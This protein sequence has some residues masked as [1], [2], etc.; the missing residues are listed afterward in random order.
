MQFLKNF[1]TSCLG[2]IIGSLVLYGIVALIISS[3]AGG[4]T[5]TVKPNTVLK[6]TFKSDM[7]EL[8]NNVE[9]GAADISSLMD[10]SV[11]MNDFTALIETAKAD[12]NIKGI[13][14]ELTD[15]T[16]MSMERSKKVHQLLT[17]FRA[18]GKFVLAYSTMYQQRDYYL[19]TAAE[20][21]YL[22]PLG[23][24]DFRGFSSQL[25][26]FKGLMDKLGVAPQIF[27]AGKFKSATEPFRRTDMSPENRLQVRE[28]MQG[29]YD[30]YLKAISEARQIPVAELQRIA[31]EALIRRPEDA[32][33]FKM[34]DELWYKDEVLAELRKRM[35]LGA[36]ETVEAVD[37][38]TYFK[39]KKDQIH[40]PKTGNKIAVVYAEGGIVDGEGQNGSIGGDKYARIIRE[41]REKD[42]V[43]A[44][45]L[46]INSGGGSALASDIIWRELELA[47]AKGIHIV[48]SMGGVAASGGYYIAANA[49]KIYAEDNT[50]TG[51]IGVFGMITNLR[52]LYEGKLG[53][54]MDT[55]RTGKYSTMSSDGGMYYTFS[56]EEGAM[57]QQMVDDIYLTFKKR[58]ADGRKMDIVLV[59]SFAQGRVWLGNAAQ[60]IGLVDSL[61]GLNQAIAEAARLSNLQT[62]A[63]TEYPKLKSGFETLLE[64]GSDKKSEYSQMLEQ[65]LQAAQIPSELQEIYKAYQTARSLNGIQMRLPFELEIK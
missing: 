60:K 17:D 23:G 18:S 46:R 30:I 26:F 27:Y 39:I 6:L 37:V 64:F 53:L 29:A 48:A 20:K 55:V 63:I 4:D 42:E 24:V 2:T 13:Y 38:S 28:Y 32:K 50:L 14:L 3:F 31:N 22:H 12:N 56:P 44:I 47:K 10:E 45:V 21:I 58:V 19:A 61:G 15:M 65:K 51:S 25:M 41:L 9:S 40:A 62:Y 5:P 16:G 7:P 52:G 36:T 35:G 49:H 34:V 54:T 59:D 57:I 1:F 8:T 11:G 33:S 43:K